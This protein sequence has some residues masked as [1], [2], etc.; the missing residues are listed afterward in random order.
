MI[1]SHPPHGVHCEKNIVGST[2]AKVKIGRV[3]I[4]TKKMGLFALKVVEILE[5][6]E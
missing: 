2:S 4:G 6:L 5:I 3:G 1:I